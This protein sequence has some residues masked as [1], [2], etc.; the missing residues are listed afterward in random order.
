MGIPDEGGGRQG[1]L[2]GEP[3]GSER[4]T[5]PTEGVEKSKKLF[6]FGMTLWL[7][8]PACSVVAFGLRPHFF[9]SAARTRQEVRGGK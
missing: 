6:V 1:L 3:Y 5:A 9:P 8:A 4:P 7:V 2:L